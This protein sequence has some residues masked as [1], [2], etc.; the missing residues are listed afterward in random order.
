M[1]QTN[2]DKMVWCEFPPTM[3]TGTK[4]VCA[5]SCLA[6]TEEVDSLNEEN[7]HKQRYGLSRFPLY[8]EFALT[9]N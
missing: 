3:G 9:E 2:A 6:P 1:D 8:V 7:T 5:V 4:F